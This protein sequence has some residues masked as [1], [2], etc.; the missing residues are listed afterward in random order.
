MRSKSLGTRPPVQTVRLGQADPSGWN[1]TEGQAGA[2]ELM[3]L[4]M[5]PTAI[6]A[7]NDMA[8]IGAITKLKE[9]KLK[10]PE[11][12]AVVGFDNI[13]IAGWYDPLLTNNGRPT[14]TPDV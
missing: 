6:V 8:A 12:V 7:S 3:R 1:V 4:Q 2:A 5:P 14:A 10:V 11:D 13:S 9:M